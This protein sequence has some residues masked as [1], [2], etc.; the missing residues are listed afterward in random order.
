M[1]IHL[2]ALETSSARCGVAL[3][4]QTGASTEVLTR[5]HDGVAEHSEK[6]LGMIDALLAEAGL[7]AAQLD[8]VAFGQG[9]GGFTGL[10]VACGVAQGLG[11]ALGRPLLPVTTHEALERPLR[12]HPAEWRLLVQDARMDERYVAIARRREAAGLAHWRQS[13]VLLPAA[14]LG[15]WF[16]EWCAEQALEIVTA[17]WLVA[18]DAALAEAPL[19]AGLPVWREP[20]QPSAAAVA[21]VGLLRWQQG[22]RLDAAAA[23]PLYVRDKVAFTSRE[24]AAGAGGNP[25]AAPGI[26]NP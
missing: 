18:G 11:F 7:K 8:A 16:A 2:L 23:H 10:R 5:H 21:E 14:H 24:R 22:V 9:P 15:D 20:L 19:P 4:R 13:P 1:A 12:D 6:L 17:A 25:R 26:R 3:L